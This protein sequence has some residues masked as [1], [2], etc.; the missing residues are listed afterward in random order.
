MIN[1]KKK[2]DE[3]QDKTK[4]KTRQQNKQDR[5]TIITIKQFLH[6]IIVLITLIVKTNCQQKTR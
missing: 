2:K 4:S 6:V 3:K 1:N 5:K